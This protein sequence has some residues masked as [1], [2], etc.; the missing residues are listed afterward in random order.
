MLCHELLA[1]AVSAD[2]GILMLR[3]STTEADR[4]ARFACSVRATEALSG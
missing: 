1:L 3:T 2:V 4:S